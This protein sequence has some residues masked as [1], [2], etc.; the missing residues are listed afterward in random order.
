MAWIGIPLSGLG[1]LASIALLY[2]AQRRWPLVVPAFVPLLIGGYVV[3]AFLPALRTVSISSAGM[4]MW[5]VVAL[6]SLPPVPVAMKFLEA[7]GG[8]SVRAEPGPE[9]D[10]F[11][12]REHE[13]ARADGLSQLSKMD[14]ETKLYEV[15][16][17]M[18]PN[19][20]VRQEAVEFARHLP[21]RQAD[22]IQMLLNLQS[23]PLVY[24]P[25]LDLQPTPELCNAARYWLHKAVVQR[26]Q[27]FHDGPQRFVGM[28]FEEGL[29][30][31]R[32]ISAHCGC[33]KELDEIEAY[34]RAQDQTAPDVQKFLAG[35]AEIREKK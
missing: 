31:I 28:E 14:D 27:M 30:G 12:A 22:M 1:A 8:G 6:L 32:W 17:W 21:N 19:S 10:R 34:A 29:A 3:Y 7:Q 26:Q 24:L 5:G 2:D 16:S 35:L 13:R 23:D 20:P 11:T 25:D 15:T 18:R 4:A 9:L 33:E